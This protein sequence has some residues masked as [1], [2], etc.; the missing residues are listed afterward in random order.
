MNTCPFPHP[1]AA[2]RAT[3]PL[4]IQNL[5]VLRGFPVPWFVAIVDG[6][7]DFRVM[8]ARKLRE[9]IRFGL[10]W[11]CGGK[12]GANKAFVIGPMCGVTRTNGEPPSHLE[13]A[14]FSAMH[15]PFLTR[16]NMKRRE[17]ELTRSL[18]GNVAGI[19]LKRNPGAVAVWASKRYENFTDGKGGILFR[20]G[21]PLGVEWYACGRSATRQ[22][23]LDSIE[24]GLPLLREAC[25]AEDPD[26]RDDAHAALTKKVAQLERHL[27][28]A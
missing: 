9:A 16:P 26:D 25:D 13:C 17:D 27:P 6:E 3:M 14:R 28:A 20:I 12:L 19:G 8:D 4:R 15:C 18:E 21:E 24:S 7:Y 1:P 2:D 10:C 5:P 11:V 22:E 23:V